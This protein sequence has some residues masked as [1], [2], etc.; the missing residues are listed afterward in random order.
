M[1]ENLLQGSLCV[2]EILLQLSVNILLQQLSLFFLPVIF[3]KISYK[4][5]VTLLLFTNF[6]IQS[7]CIETNN[8]ISLD[9][10]IFLQLRFWEILLFFLEILL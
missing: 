9:K 3:Q 7:Q 4:T 10:L 8:E 5:T 1:I 6:S 2:L